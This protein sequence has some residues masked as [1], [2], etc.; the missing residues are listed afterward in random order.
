MKK[1]S[2]ILLLS[3]YLNVAFGI[4]TD[5]YYCG[6]KLVDLKICGISV[7]S[8]CPMRS[9]HSGCCKHEA[10]YCNTDNH[11]N[12]TVV[13][14]VTPPASLKTPV[15]LLDSYSFSFVAIDQHTIFYFRSPERNRKLI[16]PLFIF[17]R[18]FRI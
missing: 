16:S 7:K 17:N 13:T 3:V 1:I 8:D 2:S 14:L 4:S 5:C 11:Q 6:N 10:H 9:A 12:P 18:V 15:F